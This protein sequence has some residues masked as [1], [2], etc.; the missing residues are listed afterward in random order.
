MN[1]NLS[2]VGERIRYLFKLNNLKQVDA[3]KKIG[4]S[5]NAISNYVNGNRIPDYKSL[6]RLSDFFDVSIDWILTGK[7]H[8]SDLANDELTL[9]NDYRKLKES[10]RFKIRGMIEL[11]LHELSTEYTQSTHINTS[12]IKETNETN[13]YIP[14]IGKVAAGKP[15]EAITYSHDDLISAPITDDIDYALTIK[16]DSMEPSIPNASTVLIKE[17]PSLETGEIGIISI[18]NYVTCKKFYQ[19]DNYIELRSI[20]SKYSPIIVHKNEQ[21]TIRI[22][23]KVISLLKP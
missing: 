19:Y 3:S 23:G 20:N 16:G 15:I 1:T 4:I 10:D 6:I 17:Q 9:L 22:I 13:K 21:H 12:Y 2:G 7:Q 8:I 5:K 11:K 18:D 14:I